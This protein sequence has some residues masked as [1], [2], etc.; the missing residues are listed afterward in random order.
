VA[1]VLIV[2]DEQLIRRGLGRMLASAGWSVMEAQHGQ[3]AL[4]VMGDRQPDVV[5]MDV[6]M[7]VMDGLEAMKRMRASSTL[8]AVPV[9]LMSGRFDGAWISS[10]APDAPF[11]QKPF[12]KNEVLVLLEDALKSHPALLT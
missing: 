6:D 7:P 9:V 1:S 10:H 5:L 4:D 8:A 2:D 11:L 12:E 3:H